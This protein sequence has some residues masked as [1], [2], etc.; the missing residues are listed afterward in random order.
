MFDAIYGKWQLQIISIEGTNFD[1][2]PKLFSVKMTKCFSE[3]QEPCS[4]NISKSA[5]LNFLKEELCCWKEIQ[6]S[7]ILENFKDIN[8]VRWKKFARLFFLR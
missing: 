2:I 4:K 8:F 1:N 5:T 6:K 3:G 7:V